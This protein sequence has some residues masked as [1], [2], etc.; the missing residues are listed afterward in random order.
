MQFTNS[1]PLL[2]DLVLGLIEFVVINRALRNWLDSKNW[3]IALAAMVATYV[4]LVGGAAALL[5]AIAVLE[6]PWWIA[7][8]LF[9]GGTAALGLTGG[10]VALVNPGALF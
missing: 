10:L 8:G 3:L 4:P 6:W 2:I 1:T 5:G 7:G 9:V